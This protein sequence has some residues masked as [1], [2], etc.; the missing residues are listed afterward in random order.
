MIR[1]LADEDFNNDILR[2]L[3]RRISR[4]DMA[5]VQDVGLTGADDATVLAHA[6]AAGRVLLSHDV[7]TLIAE[8]FER[9]RAGIAMPGV[10]A[11]AQSTAVGEAIDD[12]VLVLE[13][14]TPDDWSSQVRYVPL[15]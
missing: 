14:S 12:L 8:A 5:R 13:C 1:L 10:I 9:V 6:A 15:R 7:S 4:V 11:V 2:G 3:L